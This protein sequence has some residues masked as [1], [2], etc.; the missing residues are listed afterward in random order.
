MWGFGLFG[1]FLLFGFGLFACV[2]LFVC[3]CFT[4]CLKQN[5]PWYIYFLICTS[6]NK[7][8]SICIGFSDAVSENKQHTSFYIALWVR[9]TF[10]KQT[11]LQQ[12]TKS[13]Q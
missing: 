1:V 5:L 9:V 7:Q 2:C 4:D 11:K 13:N 3:F 8:A 10:L 6:D 12:L